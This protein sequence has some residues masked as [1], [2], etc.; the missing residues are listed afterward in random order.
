MHVEIYVIKSQN[1]GSISGTAVRGCSAVP[2]PSRAA[3]SRAAR[4]RA[5]RP[6]LASRRPAHLGDSD[7]LGL[8]LAPLLLVVK[9]CP[10]R[11]G[12]RCQR[13][14]LVFQHSV[15]ISLILPVILPLDSSTGSVG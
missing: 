8:V 15:F 2:V 4:S 3:L 12:E 7:T 6:A 11:P 10:G 13:S 5:A 1:R 9:E 14:T